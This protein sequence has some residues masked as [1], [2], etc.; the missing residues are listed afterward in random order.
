MSSNTDTIYRDLLTDVAE[1]VKPP[2]VVAGRYGDP[3][4]AL[5][6]AE[7][8]VSADPDMARLERIESVIKLV[9][10]DLL[11]TQV[12]GDTGRRLAEFQR[13][14]GFLLK[15]KSYTIKAATP[16]GYSMFFQKDREGFSFQRHITHKTELF[17]IVSVKPGGYIFICDFADWER[18]YEPESFACWMD[19]QEDPRYEQFR[20]RP[21]PGDVV[22]VDKLGT[23]H[24]VIGC[25]LEEYATVSTDM[26]VRL[27][28][29]NVG[30]KVPA[31]FTR[32]NSLRQLASVTMP[33]LSTHVTLHGASPAS[34]ERL[35][36]KVM[37][38]GTKTT[39]HKSFL[40]ASVYRVEPHKQL[41][42]LQVGAD[43]AVVYV[44]EGSG[45]GIVVGTEDELKTN[46]LPALDLARGQTAFVAPGLS[47]SFVNRGDETLVVSEQRI[48]PSVCLV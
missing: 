44:G 14:L 17:H 2:S 30:K 35:A 39:L 6:E 21:E 19:G 33:E 13:K 12:S 37:R 20:Y 28:D 7:R 22:V 41:E 47:Y 26:V 4:A 34:K 36:P 3:F 8:L 15:Y 43:G 40:E 23:V 9:L 16:L 10:T 11:A 5:Y 38:G 31:D 27:H 42:S 45:G 46:R 25:V 1:G 32:A 29:Q 48:K 18:V 24:T